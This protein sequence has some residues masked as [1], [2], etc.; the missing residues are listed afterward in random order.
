MRIISEI[1]IIKN[2]NRDYSH[3][4]TFFFIGYS[5]LKILTNKHNIMNCYISMGFITLK[6]HLVFTRVSIFF[7]V[8][9][10]LHNWWKHL[11]SRMEPPWFQSGWVK[12]TSKSEL[13]EFLECEEPFEHDYSRHHSEFLK[14]N[15]FQWKWRE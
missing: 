11:Q 13:Q 8:K 14:V 12:E 15:L 4:K 9:S 3:L 5:Y 1:L 7:L 10:W 6:Y 2:Y